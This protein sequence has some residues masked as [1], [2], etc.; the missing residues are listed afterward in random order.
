MQSASVRHEAGSLTVRTVVHVVHFQI[1]EDASVILQRVGSGPMRISVR[2]QQRRRFRIDP[3]RPRDRHSL[4]IAGRRD[5]AIEPFVFGNR[6]QLK[7]VS[8]SASWTGVACAAS[9]VARYSSLCVVALLSGRVAVC[10]PL[11]QAAPLPQCCLWGTPQGAG[12]IRR[13]PPRIFVASLKGMG[14]RILLRD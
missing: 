2:H 10:S 14:P 4:H 7:A 11:G 6:R 9:P 8:C 1:A 13:T 5:A 12:P 3:G